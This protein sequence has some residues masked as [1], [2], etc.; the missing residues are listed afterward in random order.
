MRGRGALWA[1]VIALLPASVLADDNVRIQ[2][3]LEAGTEVDTN[4]R[5]ETSTGDSF[6]AEPAGVGRGAARLNLTFRPAPRRA[7]RL[8]ALAAGKLYQGIT[9]DSPSEEDVAV[10]AADARYDARLASRPLG[11][12]LRLSYY[13]AVERDTFDDMGKSVDHDFRTGDATAQ[14]TLLP[15]GGGRVTASFGWRAFQYKPAPSYDFAGE[16]AGIGYQRALERDGA[17]DEPGPT[18]ELA[19]D[20]AIHRRAYDGPAYTRICA[21]DAELTSACL[22]PSNLQRVDL[23]HIAAVEV[24]YAGERL[25]SARYELQ[26]D[27]SNS[28]GQSLVRHRLELSATTEA[29][30]SVFVTAKATAQVIQFLDPLLLSR[31]IGVLTI[32]EENR[33]ALTVH[34]TRELGEAWALEARWALYTNE[35]ATQELRYRRQTFY[36]GAVYSF[37]SER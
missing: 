12:G 34:A 19:V 22:A 9:G 24:G 14:L 36:L 25:W 3:K 26:V 27:D 33:N 7:L 11:L 4:A 28:F 16:H 15:D 20:Y 5:R 8:S 23:L 2:L 18:W 30:W 21:D 35:F 29:W 32:E 1:A 10:L 17:G 37:D 6:I 13:D 31:D